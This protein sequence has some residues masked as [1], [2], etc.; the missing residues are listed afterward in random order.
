MSNC[1]GC[2]HDAH[3]PKPCAACALGNNTC[4]TGIEI[5]GGDGDQAALGDIEL[6][7]GMERNPCL[8]CRNF[9]KDKQKLIRHL[10]AC[11][12]EPDENGH[13]LTPIAKDFPGRKSLKI[14]PNTFGFCRM[15]G[16][17]VDMLGT[18]D[19]FTAVRTSGEL[20]SRIKS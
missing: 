13:F 20:E 8:L 11:K 7:T 6:A 15:D 18:C 5:T 14:N 12:L 4:F 3:A 1:P 9:E 19:S 10:M 17:V 2:G 16:I